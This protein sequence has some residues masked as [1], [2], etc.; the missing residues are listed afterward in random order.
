[1]DRK[2][3]EEIKAKVKAAQARLAEQGQQTVTESPVAEDPKGKI[4]ESVDHM[5]EYLNRND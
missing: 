5:I 2:R 1:M 3:Y 4:F